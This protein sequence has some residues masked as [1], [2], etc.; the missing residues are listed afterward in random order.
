MLP[1]G[2]GAM[3]PGVQAGLTG[4]SI[5]PIVKEYTVALL[6][7]ILGGVSYPLMDLRKLAVAFG[8]VYRQIASA[9]S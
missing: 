6:K 3:A 2:S 9:S 4:A 5:Y 1:R 7:D 8:L